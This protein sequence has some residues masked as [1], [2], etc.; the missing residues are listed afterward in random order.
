MAEKMIPSPM[1]E[2]MQDPLDNSPKDAKVGVQ[3]IKNLLAFVIALVQGGEASL[4]DGKISFMDIFNFF[5]AIISGASAVKHL[6][7]LKDELENITA[8]HKVELCEFV[9]T[10]LVMN[11]KVI[12]E[13]VDKALCLIISLLDFI[14]TL[15]K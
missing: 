14:P 10:K 12:E 11:D 5:Q 9:S 4:A 13:C 1:E 8:D 6:D 15:K 2:A 7:H 3:E